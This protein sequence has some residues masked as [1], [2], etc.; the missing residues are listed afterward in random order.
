M[1]DDFDRFATLEVFVADY[2]S[3]DHGVGNEATDLL[4]NNS[5][6]SG[7][8]D[9]A[10]DVDSFRVTSPD[11]LVGDPKSEGI[12]AA[13]MNRRI[14]AETKRY[15]LRLT[16]FA[17]GMDAIVKVTTNSGTQTYETGALAFDEYWTVPVDLQPGESVLVEVSNKDGSS[18]G[19]SYSISFG[20]PLLDED[21]GQPDTSN[22]SF[23][24]PL[25]QR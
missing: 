5:D 15:V 13:A 6:R 4:A 23:Y 12:S 2:K 8:I 10:G 22:Q 21:V 16:D 20:S 9:S 19:S 24:L 14:N 11:S 3:N 7:R 18:T 1:P 17:F 25:I